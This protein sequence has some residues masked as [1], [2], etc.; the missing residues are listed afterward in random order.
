M[1]GSGKI[2]QNETTHKTHRTKIS[3]FSITYWK[4]HNHQMDI[5][6]RPASIYFDKIPNR[7]QISII[8]KT[9][10]RMVKIDDFFLYLRI[11]EQTHLKE[12]FTLNT[13]G[14]VGK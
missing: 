9:P 4:R 11:I 7:S 14:S 5:A 10:H 8:E 6:R 2:T 12:T 3:P 13:R 1:C